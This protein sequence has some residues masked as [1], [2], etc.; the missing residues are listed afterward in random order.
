MYEQEKLSCMLWEDRIS[1]WMRIV[2]EK[3]QKIYKSSQ[4]GEAMESFT[5]DEISRML[6]SSPEFSHDDPFF[7]FSSKWGLASGDELAAY[8]GKYDEEYLA[9]LIRK[10]GEDIV[11]RSSA[12]PTDRAFVA[13][14]LADYIEGLV[15]SDDKMVDRQMPDII[16]ERFR[17][18]T[19][20]RYDK[21]LPLIGV[22]MGDG[23]DAMTFWQ[24]L[25]AITM[26]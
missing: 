5:L 20:G 22:F 1:L 16:I 23:W 13:E 26:H 19:N 2:T 25:H 3:R 12:Y 11:P 14:R 4:F 17:K 6:R 9:N 10:A 8:K 18:D 21:S 15:R 7:W 24:F